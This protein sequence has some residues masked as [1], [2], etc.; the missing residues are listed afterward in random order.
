MQPWHRHHFPIFCL[1]K[2]GINDYELV[3]FARHRVRSLLLVLLVKLIFWFR[4]TIKHANNYFPIDLLFYMFIKKTIDQNLS[5]CELYG[6]F[7]ET[8][9]E[10]TE[11]GRSELNRPDLWIV[12]IIIIMLSSEQSWKVHLLEKSTVHCCVE[13]A[14]FCNN[15]D[16]YSLD[17][18]HLHRSQDIPCRGN[19]SRR[20]SIAANEQM[21]AEQVL[22]PH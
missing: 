8:K 3:W 12:I 6:L 17:R 20:T 4:K 18:L 7:A 21:G 16:I 11:P 10:W 1:K 13:V 15:L 22:Q 14:N 2:T 19:H 9:T 5:T